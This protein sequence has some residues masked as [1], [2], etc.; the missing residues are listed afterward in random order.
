MWNCDL[1]FKLA[2]IYMDEGI[3]DVRR[4]NINIVDADGG[5]IYIAMLCYA[6]FIILAVLLKG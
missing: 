5:A 3:P 2:R 1:G 6:V 4:R